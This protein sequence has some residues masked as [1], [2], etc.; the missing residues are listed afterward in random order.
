VALGFVVDDTTEPTDHLSFDASIRAA[1]DHEHHAGLDH[2]YEELVQRAK[3]R[4]RMGEQANLLNQFR[5]N[6]TGE[7]HNTFLTVVQEH[8]AGVATWV[9]MRRLKGKLGVYVGDIALAISTT[10]STEFEFWLVPR[11]RTKN[12]INGVRPIQMLLR[13]APT[14]ADSCKD[15]YNSERLAELII[16]IWSRGSLYSRDGFLILHGPPTLAPSFGGQVLP[17]PHEFGFFTFCEALEPSFRRQTKERMAQNTIVIG[18]RVK[19]IGELQGLTGFVQDVSED[20]V[21][22]HLPSMDLMETVMRYEVRKEFR[23]GDQVLISTEDDG[24]DKSGWIIAVNGS[25][26]SVFD[27]KD[28]VEVRIMECLILYIH[29]TWHLF[30]LIA[31]RINFVSMTKLER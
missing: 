11:P 3:E 15:K 8:R 26:I 16:K 13:A 5:V 10:Q 30:R 21:T 31:P 22:V 28:H 6:E 27:P 19:C 4:A 24:E 17:T 2:E 12:R 9:R 14:A 29:I 25:T 20:T 1:L 7:I 23:I 18:D